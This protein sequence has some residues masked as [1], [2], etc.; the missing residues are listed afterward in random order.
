MR[1]I[2]SRSSLAA[3]LVIGMMALI[4]S[5]QLARADVEGLVVVLFADPSDFV[6]LLDKPGHCGSS[7][8]HI[9][10]SSTNFKEMVALFMTAFSLSKRVHAVDDSC[11]GNRNIM[12]HAWTF[13]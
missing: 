10:R 7:F 3:T 1:K 11:E 13:P 2:I 5:I 4:S 6:V 12:S 8:F 9:K